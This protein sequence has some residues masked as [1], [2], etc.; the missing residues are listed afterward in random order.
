MHGH[1]IPLI[2]CQH[3]ASGSI[4]SVGKP[5]ADCHSIRDPQLRIH[6]FSSSSSDQPHPA[7]TSVPR[8]NLQTSDSSLPAR[9]DH[10]TCT[11]LL[12]QY[13]ASYALSSCMPPHFWVYNC[14]LST[15]SGEDAAPQP[16]ATMRSAAPRAHG[17]RG[18]PA[19]RRCPQKVTAT[20]LVQ[21]A[22][23]STTNRMCEPRIQID[24]VVCCLR[25]HLGA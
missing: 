16:A 22:T 25:P 24:P 12:S 21:P 1:R 8:R 19:W 3:Q 17:D 23:T 7:G 11:Q 20:A 5:G 2:H 9:C 14:R 18:G 15:A 10:R 6:R 4:V 13:L